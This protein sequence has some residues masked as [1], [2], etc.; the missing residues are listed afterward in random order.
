M[1]RPVKKGSAMQTRRT[2]LKSSLALGGIGAGLGA[3]PGPLAQMGA[4]AQTGGYKALVCVFLEGGMD[5]HD[6]LIPTDAEG[7]AAWAGARG[8]LLSDYEEQGDDSR[9]R[10]ALIPLGGTASGH[11]I[12]LPR[13]MAPLADLYGVGRLG[14][15]ANVGPSE[16]IATAAD[17]KAGRA[18]TPRR[19][20]SHND[21]Q[22]FWETSSLEGTPTGWA[23]RMQDAL[24]AQ[25]SPYSA[26]SVGGPATF[27]AGQ[28][29]VPFAMNRQGPVALHGEAGWAYGHSG[30]KEIMEAHYR[31]GA[32]RM[33]N[34]LAS[35]FK[36]EQRRAVEATLELHG[37]MEASRVGDELIDG[38]DEIAQQF[39][40]IAK[41]IS[42]RSRLSVH[43]Q[44]FFVKLGGFDTHKDQAK[45]LPGL[46]A[47]LAKAM[48]A[49]YRHTVNQ[50]LAQD[51]TTFTA[52]E[53]GRTLTPNDSG[54]DHGWGG[55]HMVMGGAV[56]GGRV[57]GQL[58]DAG[59]GHAQDHG[60]GRLVPTMAT[61][62]YAA[63]LGSWFGV[64][65]AGL[66]EALP[67]LSRFDV[68]PA[69]FRS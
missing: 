1:I 52:S 28:R 17:I 30:V 26:I 55:H 18:K 31:A 59:L 46:Q 56:A 32:A 35:D 66:A 62:Q 11:A 25:G 29:T 12:G 4:L 15:V 63:A 5:C 48:A 22:S 20:M 53:F 24:S 68:P 57:H 37:L 36:T 51:V 41:I 21:Q 19:L 14:I 43:R 39:A 27:L 65:R 10:E 16:G 23:G 47:R 64:D 45:A 44:T 33:D 9:R 67:K 54:T 8:R 3:L 2:L 34:I 69:L 50:G 60:R 6:T 13:Q 42:L 7:Y 40:T 61:E 58:P 49:F 38:E